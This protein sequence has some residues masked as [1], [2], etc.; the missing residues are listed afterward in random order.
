MNNFAFSKINFILIGISMVIAVIGFLL[1][2]GASSDETNF[3]SEIFSDV[4]IKVAPVI[5]LVGFL[6]VIFGIMYRPKNK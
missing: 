2:I 5:C 4:R 6:S 3:N 1:M